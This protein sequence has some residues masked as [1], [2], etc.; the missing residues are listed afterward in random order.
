[1]FKVTV[2]PIILVPVFGVNDKWEITG[3]VLS[4]KLKV[5]AAPASCVAVAATLTCSVNAPVKSG[6]FGVPALYTVQSVPLVENSMAAVIPVIVF[7]VSSFET[8]A[9]AGPS[10]WRLRLLLNL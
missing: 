8:P 7:A 1:M 2:W 4:I 6:R 10:A 3:G 5:V 9:N